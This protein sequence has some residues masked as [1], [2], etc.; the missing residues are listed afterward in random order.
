MIAICALALGFGAALP[1]SEFDW[2]VREFSRQSGA[3]P[4]HIPLFGLVRFTVAIAHP[5]GTSEL[6]LAVF[7]HTSFE[8]KK[9]AEMTD[10]V[11]GGRW[12]PIVR[13]RSRDRESTSIY[14]QQSGK[15]LRLLVASLDGHEGTFV[16]VRIK[17]EQLMKFIDDRGGCRRKT[18]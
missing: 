15:E 4:T 2:L 11:A 3:E 13:V 7:E 14:A 5:V 17:P 1:A 9:F 8:P 10:S 6:R 18:M 12:K 16:Q